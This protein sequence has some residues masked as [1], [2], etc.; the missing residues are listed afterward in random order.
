MISGQGRVEWRDL[1]RV[2]YAKAWRMQEDLRRERRAGRIPDR[3]LLLEHDPVITQG[4]RGI[5][6]DVLSGADA[7]AAEGIEL[8]VTNRGGRATYHGPGQLVGYFIFDLAKAR[9]GVREFVRMVEEML[10]GTVGEFGIRAE[11]DEGHPGIWAGGEKLAAIGLNV[12]HGVTQHGFALNAGCDLSPYRHIVACGISDRGVTTME[13]LLD[14]PV[15]M[16]ELK[17]AAVGAAAAVFGRDMV[18]WDGR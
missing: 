10:I 6:S 7:L 5:A 17:R 3:L 15:G 4:R 9:L 14:R 11:R 2:R 18:E 8:V 16:D 13:R 12:S 1:G